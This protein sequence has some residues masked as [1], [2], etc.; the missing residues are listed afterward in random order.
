MVMLHSNQFGSALLDTYFHCPLQ[1][2][3]NHERSLRVLFGCTHTD[4]TVEYLPDAAG[5]N[6][7]SNP[8]MLKAFISNNAFNQKFGFAT[9]V[10]WLEAFWSLKRKAR[11][12]DTY[13]ESLVS[14]TNAL[15]ESLA[16]D[17]NENSPG[18]L[19]EDFMFY[20]EC[21]V[22]GHPHLSEEQFPSINLP[23]Y[24]SLS[25]LANVSYIPNLQQLQLS[26]SMNNDNPITNI[27]LQA[28]SYNLSDTKP[29]C[30]AL[31]GYIGGGSDGRLYF[32]DNTGRIP[33]IL[34]DEI[35]YGFSNEALCMI[36]SCSFIEE[37][38][39]YINDSG[40]RI[41]SQ[42]R[43]LV[44]KYSSIVNLQ[45]SKM[46]ITFCTAIPS[47]VDQ[48]R[49]FAYEQGPNLPFT[50]NDSLKVFYVRHLPTSN[51]QPNEFGKQYL[52][53]A[54][55]VVLFDLIDSSSIA[56]CTLWPKAQKC[57][58][59]LTSHSQSLALLPIVKPK[60]WYVLVNAIEGEPSSQPLLHLDKKSAIYPIIPNGGNHKLRQFTQDI[61]SAPISG[62]TVASEELNVKDL[63][64]IS[65]FDSDPNEALILS[66]NFYRHLVS[67]EAYV[68]TK[69]FTESNQAGVEPDKY[70]QLY[71]ENLAIGTGRPNR[72]LFLKLRSINS[73]DTIDVYFNV[74]KK[75]YPIGL[76]AGC[77]IKIHKVALKVSERTKLVYGVMIPCSGIEIMDIP[78]DHRMPDDIVESNDVENRVL[79]DFL[80]DPSNK[81]YQAV[82]HVKSIQQIS[83]SWLCLECGQLVINDNCYDM[84]VKGRRLF[85]AQA[86]ATMTDG[87]A[88]ITVSIEGEDMV[89]TLLRLSEIAAGKLKEA[90]YTHGEM[91]YSNW[92]AKEDATIRDASGTSSGA[93]LTSRARTLHDICANPH[94][95]TCV[96]L[97]ARRVARRGDYDKNS[98]QI[99][100]FGK[101]H[102]LPVKLV[103]NDPEAAIQS[104][105]Y[106]RV[107]LH[108]VRLKPVDVIEQANALL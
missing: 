37:D 50:A 52:S 21:S 8:S 54:A 39:S 36:K 61:P 38:L 2:D 75:L 16:L 33:V 4:I 9:M 18:N 103:S 100:L 41:D 89:M 27:P 97:Q 77:R 40:H 6:C 62:S 29:N 106:T 95:F 20:N 81:A 51:L 14:Q 107:R 57:T 49:I 44:I 80:R 31:V 19:V 25:Q 17:Q 87:T 28:W 55:E 65:F 22:F 82:C 90:A 13:H 35:E 64:N 79:S 66:N 30:C 83:L 43:Y 94:I 86:V 91:V 88:D 53:C 1:S 78:T 47:T 46:Q 63:V 34:M 67:F 42:C 11:D 104:L 23:N 76:I 15:V 60:N 105:V 102:V 48:G 96:S 26:S 74:G 69:N 73:Q 24:P 85:V 7:Q 3:V 98:S 99:N 56:T 70:A 32:A 71:Y 58:L 10:M 68:L 101:I 12:A 45:P 5:R 84:C 72:W 93:N 108:V 59:I 92:F